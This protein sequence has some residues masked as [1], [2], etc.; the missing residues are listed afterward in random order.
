MQLPKIQYIEYW[1]QHES[2]SSNGIK[3]SRLS[4]PDSLDY[5]AI[6]VIDLS[7]GKLWRDSSGSGT[8]S[9]IDSSEDINNLAEMIRES[10]TSKVI[11]LLPLDCEV[12]YNFKYSDNK[13][14]SSE[15]LKNGALSLLIYYIEKLIQVYILNICSYEPTKTRIGNLEYS[16]NFYFKEDYLGNNTLITKSEGSNK[17]TTIVNEG[18]FISTLNIESFD[19]FLLFLDKLEL[20]SIKEDVPEWIKELVMFDDKEQYRKIEEQEE[21]IQKSNSII[22]ISKNKLEQNNRFKSILYTNGDELVEVVF[23]MLEKMLSCNLSGF[24]DEKKEDFLIQL[25]NVTFIGEIKGVTSNIKS[26]HVSQLDVHYQGYIDKLEEEGRQE[27]VKALLIMDHQ[28]NNPLKSRQ[29]VHINQ[30]NLAKRNKSLIIETSE[31]LHLY[32]AFLKGSVTSEQIIDRF[33]DE[34][35]LFV[36]DKH[37][38]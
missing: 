21:I 32:E 27:N 29:E 37:E 26:E 33:A 17:P 8:L 38:N 23:E 4:E 20:I 7:E 1:K 28:R 16:G 22:S 24:K 10:K 5:Y 6:N 18:K 9:R 2:F 12:Y 15:K 35:G 36:Y 30:I 34:T 14:H 25:S 19:H 11:I 13:F 3:H 31:L